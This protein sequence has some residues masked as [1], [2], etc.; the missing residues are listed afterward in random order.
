MDLFLNILG[1]IL[2]VLT[3]LYIGKCAFEFYLA[4]KMKRMVRRFK[5]EGS[6]FS[7]FREL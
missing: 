7:D 1:I 5:D 6:N 3:G 2:I 4:C